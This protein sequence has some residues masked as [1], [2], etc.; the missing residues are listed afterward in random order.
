MLERCR[1]RL[2][3]S[4]SH[5]DSLDAVAHDIAS[6]AC[7]DLRQRA[8]RRLIGDFCATFPLRG[9]NMNRG[10]AKIIFRIMHKSH[11]AN[12]FAPELLEIRLRL[13]MDRA[14]KP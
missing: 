9:E 13:V 2:D 14:D 11:K 5:D 1:D 12:V 3:V 8:G 7:G 6:L 10:L 4:G